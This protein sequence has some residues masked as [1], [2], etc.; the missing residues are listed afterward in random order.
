MHNLH[1]ILLDYYDYL[2]MQSYLWQMVH[3]RD[4]DHDV[5]DI[6]E[7]LLCMDMG[8]DSPLMVVHHCHHR[9]RRS[10]WSSY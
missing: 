4:T 8:M 10:S 5:L 7:N 9:V 1:H 3:M 2:M 6:P